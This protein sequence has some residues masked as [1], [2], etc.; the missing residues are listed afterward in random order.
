MEIDIKI[1][2]VLSFKT[3]PCNPFVLKATQ[4]NRVSEILVGGRRDKK[5]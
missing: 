1:N 3:L 2:V 4:S 5:G